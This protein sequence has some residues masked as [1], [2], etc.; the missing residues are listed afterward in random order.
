[1]TSN[2][3]VIVLGAGLCGSLLTCYLANQGLHVEVYERRADMRNDTNAAV[4]RSINLALSAR[5]IEAL[6]KVGFREEVMSMAI[7][8][9]G[10]T[11]HSTDGKLTFQP[12]SKDGE[13]Y[14]NS[15][16]RGDLN[17]RLMTL[18]EKNPNVKYFFEHKVVNIDLKNEQV[19]VQLPSG[20]TKVVKGQTII[21][22]DG[23]YSVAR[24]TM[25]HMSRYNYSQEYLPTGYKELHI[26]PGPNGEH[27]IDKNSLHIWPRGHLMM[28]ALPNQD[29][30]FTVTCFFPFDGADGF[31]VLDRADDATLTQFFEEKFPDVVP[32]IPSLTHDFRNNPTSSLVTIK[33]WPWSV[34]GNICLLGDASHAIVPFFGQGM[35]AAF[36]DC[37]VFDR[38]KR[39]EK[40]DW[41]QVFKKFQ[42]E[43]KRNTDAIAQ[44]AEENH[45]EMRDKV[46][47]HTFLWRKKV[48]RLL[49]NK[50]PERFLSRYELVSFSLMPYKDALDRGA[51]NGE[52][53]NTHND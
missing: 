2:E 42:E 29:G 43:R 32:L 6:S 23:A 38:I 10:R 52:I 45:Y 39:E 13:S 21:A 41:G 5:G 11:M 53:E 24:G 9:K 36:E 47:D 17:C 18:S 28:I 31:D 27:L 51:I 7:P 44:M 50:F 15:I 19:T 3:P 14:I 25:M 37:L 46:G 26:P 12:Y 1:M 22:T 20:E 35:N 48:E 40:G 33:C 30:S 4:G 34:N 8:M 16:S 49:G